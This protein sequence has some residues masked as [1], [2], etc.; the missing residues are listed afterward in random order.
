VSMMPT[1]SSKIKGAPIRGRNRKL[2]ASGYSLAELMVAVAIGLV[3]MAGLT[4]VFA[5][6]I[7]SRSEIERTGQQ[8]DNGR[9]AMQLLTDDLRNAGYLAEFNPAPLATPSSKPDACA[10]DLAALNVALPLA[11]QGYDNGVNA[12][13]CL[14]DLRPGTDVL[15]IR[16]ASTCAMGETTCDAQVNGVP[17]FQASG[18]SSVTELS[19]VNAVS[20]YALDSNVANL[21]MHQRDCT[22]LAAYRQYRVHIYFVANNDNSGDGI[23]TLKRAE[24]GASGFIIVPLV[25]GVESLQIE[26][27]L[28][29][30]AATTGAPAAF[31]ANPDSYNDCAGAGCISYWRNVVAAKVNILAR[32]TTV[33]PGFSDSKTYHLGLNANNSI[34]T[35]GPFN[36]GFKRHVYA[37]TVRLNNTSGRNT[38]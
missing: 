22:T 15:V 29:T 30:P 27:G 26:Y 28:D 5:N 11:V 32:N 20:Y 16:R 7:R 38:P 25:E 14:T 2:E 33:T 18:C 10:T 19:A 35:L 1:K 4:A 23:P 12:P 9:F 6:S 34:N 36:D 24:L 31:T 21:T 17:Y 3:V 13:A 37:A 8:I